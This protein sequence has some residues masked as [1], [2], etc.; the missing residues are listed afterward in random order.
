MHIMICATHVV[1][2][3][4]EEAQA[5]QERLGIP[6]ANA[7]YFDDLQSKFTWTHGIASLVGSQ[8]HFDTVFSR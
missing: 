6:N 1:V 2:F 8:Q 5:L 4:T 3:E 7:R